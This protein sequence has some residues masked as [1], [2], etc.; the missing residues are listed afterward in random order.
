MPIKSSGIKKGKQR[1]LIKVVN[2]DCSYKVLLSFSGK[3]KKHLKPTSVFL[4][5]KEIDVII[6]LIKLGGIYLTHATTPAHFIV[7]RGLKHYLPHD[8]LAL[9]NIAGWFSQ[10]FKKRNVTDNFLGGLL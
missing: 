9:L 10:D 5:E 6:K 7:A 4:S 8:F 2:N 3:Y 1:A